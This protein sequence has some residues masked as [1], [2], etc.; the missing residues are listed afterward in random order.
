MW[1]DPLDGAAKAGPVKENFFVISFG[2]TFPILIELK[3]FRSHYVKSEE[4]KDKKAT[5]ELT[6]NR[7]GE[8]EEHETP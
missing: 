6:I 1:A 2:E 4:E 5:E 8:G 3:Y 7:R